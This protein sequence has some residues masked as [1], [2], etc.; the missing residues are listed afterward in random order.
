MSAFSIRTHTYQHLVTL[1]SLSLS[2]VI[3]LSYKCI[4][5]IYLK[6]YFL[7]FIHKICTY[8]G[9]IMLL[10]SHHIGGEADQGLPRVPDQGR[11]HQHGGHHLQERRVPRLRHPRR[12]QAVGHW[13]GVKDK[14]MRVRNERGYKGVVPGD[15]N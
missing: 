11:P 14:G 9:S 3:Y 12:H 2:L 1:V 10:F 4:L 5:Q 15:K 6:Y 8:A 13:H 7:H